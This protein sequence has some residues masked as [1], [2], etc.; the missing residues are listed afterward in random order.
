MTVA[1][2]LTYHRQTNHLTQDAVA[3]ALQISR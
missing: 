3:Q 2:Q 1:E